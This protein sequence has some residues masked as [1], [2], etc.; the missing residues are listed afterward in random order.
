MEVNFKLCFKLVDDQLRLLNRLLNLVVDMHNS[1]ESL[2]WNRVRKIERVIVVLESKLNVLS[3]AL[4]S[5]L[6]KIGSTDIE[7]YISH[8]VNYETCINS[9]IARDKGTVVAA[10]NLESPD[11]GLLEGELNFLVSNGVNKMQWAL[12]RLSRYLMKLNAMHPESAD[13]YVKLK[14]QLGKEEWW[15]KLSDEEKT[16]R[17]REAGDFVTLYHACRDSSSKD[18]LING[19]LLDKKLAING[20]LWMASSS[21]CARYAASMHNGLDPRFMRVIKIRMKRK[22]ATQFVSAPIEAIDLR[23]KSGC[24]YYV[25]DKKNFNIIN[26]EIMNGTVFFEV[27]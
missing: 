26:N 27:F 24:K 20:G 6:N 2:D 17:I 19:G 1:L 4:I 8:I 21:A 12:N 3:K 9:K 14:D 22:I 5:Q 7:K 10:L 11:V 25:I 15:S 16:K 18:H 23:E 13:S